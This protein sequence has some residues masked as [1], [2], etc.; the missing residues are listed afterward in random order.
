M[1]VFIVLLVIVTECV[2]GDVVT[3]QDVLCHSSAVKFNVTKQ[4]AI[5]SQAFQ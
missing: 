3:V 1:N 2:N 5:G 4:C